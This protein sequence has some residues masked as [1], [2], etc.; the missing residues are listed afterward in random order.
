VSQLSIPTGERRS[1]QMHMAA[2]VNASLCTPMKN[3]RLF[4]NSNRQ[5]AWTANRLD[6]QAR[7]SQ[8]SNPLTDLN[9]AED[10]SR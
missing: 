2:T 6:L 5:F 1:L 9:Q 8:N 10:T 7:F 4:W 3:W